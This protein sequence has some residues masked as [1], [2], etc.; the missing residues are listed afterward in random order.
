M[1]GYLWRRGAR[2][3]FQ[4][5]V[6]ID[7]QGA[8]GSTPVRLPLPCDDHR[9]ASR[10]ARRLAG[11]AESWFMELKKERFTG[12]A[13]LAA[14]RGQ[15]PNVRERL[16]EQ[17]AKEIREITRQVAELDDLRK[18]RVVGSDREMIAHL[19]HRNSVLESILA[20]LDDKANAIAREYADFFAKAGSERG[21]LYDQ[22]NDN[23][24]D[25]SSVAAEAYH[26]V[27]QAEGRLESLKT[28]VVEGEELRNHVSRETLIALDESKRLREANTALTQRL[29]YKG[30]LLSDSQHKFLDNMR[31]RGVSKKLVADVSTKIDLFIALIGDKHLGNYLISD[32]QRFASRLSHL[33]QK[34]SVSPR[35]RG[36]PVVEIIVENEERRSSKVEYLT[37][38][39]IINNFVGRVKTAIR[40][41]SAE[42]GIDNPF[43]EQIRIVAPAA[44]S[45]VIRHGFAIEQVNSLVEHAAFAKKA[46]EAWLPIVALLTGTRIGEL[47]MLCP[48]EIEQRNGIWVMDLTRQGRDHRR[49]PRSLK[50]ETSRRF[51]V[52]HRKL[53]ELGFHRWATD[54]SRE[55]VF[56]DF[57]RAE[58]PANAA[59]KRFQRLF[60]LWGLT[61][62]NTE[63]FHALRHTYKDLARAAGVEERTIALQTGHS[64]DGVAMNYGS[65]MLR[66]DEMKR[67]S[68]I[69]LPSEWNLQPYE[70]LLHRVAESDPR[71]RY[72]KRYRRFDPELD[73]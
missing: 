45:S 61:G 66:P 43:R 44:R 30:P 40:W 59:S 1:A 34:H 60:K 6:P 57:H 47:V 55:W 54:T 21:R 62:R 64:L 65:K 19:K 56:E 42:S 32:L 51:A 37:E 10:Y 28:R 46:D 24:A 8:F 3:W 4:I 36:R 22:M 15:L 14:E 16:Y 18:P 38:N 68:E 26:T 35:W 23:A 7:L 12:L 20:N 72:K 69:D 50:T 41:L 17:L 53:I 9:D 27:K 11:I 33:P 52:I 39:T 2:F 5:A 63:V 29:D 67:L 31:I 13:K 73:H 25:M 71:S 49:S 70:G 58:A 48:D